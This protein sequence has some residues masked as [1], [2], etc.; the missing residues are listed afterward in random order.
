MP[1]ASSPPRSRSRRANRRSRHARAWSDSWCDFRPERSGAPGETEE[2]ADSA[3]AVLEAH[4]DELG[5]CRALCL[6]AR[7]ELIEGHMAAADE[8][9][10]RAAEHALHVGDEAA[11]FEILD[12]RAAAALFGPTP[13]SVAI[14]R[15]REIHEQLNGSPV[16][17]A[18][19][20]RPMAALH[21]MAGE[22]E[23][24][25]RLVAAGDEILGELGGLQAAITQQEALVE[26]LADRPDAAEATLRRGYEALA[27]MG[28]KA[29]L[30]TTA[31]MLAQAV[32][33]QGR[34]EEAAELCRV[35]E[36]CAAEEDVSAQVESRA[37]RAK[38][39][40]AEGRL[41]EAEALAAEAVRLAE[42]TD[43]LTLHAGALMDLGEVLGEAGRSEEAGAAVEAALE[44]YLRKGDV[45]S[46]ERA[47][48][49]L[50]EGNQPTEAHD[51]QVHDDEHQ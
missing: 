12:W 42:R 6:R 43:F 13:V 15:C 25:R 27:E 16:A 33:A 51:G 48:A 38:L 26:L 44:L 32:Y 49:R 10:E 29:L 36:E 3:L 50:R 17:A 31:A 39:I 37:V 22:L 9:W 7:Q 45:V 18:R 47:R 2:I 24:A 34:H 4:G 41:E 28:E 1:I 30:A 23:E 14:A 46:S 21:A 5:Q 40:A 11:L 8:A 20:L 19:I 35:S